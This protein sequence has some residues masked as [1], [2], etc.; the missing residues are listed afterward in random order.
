MLSGTAGGSR[1]SASARGAWGPRRCSAAALGA[2]LLLTLPA[3][4]FRTIVPA[5]IALALV[6]ILAQPRL[7]KLI[8]ARRGAHPEHG[9]AWAAAGVFATGI[10]G[11]YFGAAQGILLLA[12][13]G[14][15]IPDDLHRTNALKIVLAT[16]VNLTAG[17]IFVFAADV[18]WGPAALIAAGS[19]VGGQLGAHYG[20]RL[21]PDALRALIVVVGLVA[22]AR[23]VTG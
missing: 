14:L 6:L 18:A 2:A 17:I 19:V 5:F 8:A 7:T 22:I 11:G 12:I 21:H 16:L 1:A 4:W 13:L 9:G 23:L 20:Q 15:T 10:Y 3:A